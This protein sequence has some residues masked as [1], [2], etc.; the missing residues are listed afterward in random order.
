MSL[1][2]SRIRQGWLSTL[3]LGAALLLSSCEGKKTLPVPPDDGVEG[4]PSSAQLIV[5]PDTPVRVYTY[6]D[7]FPVGPSDRDSLLSVQEIYTTGPGAVQGMIF[8]FTQAERFEVFR[9]EAV[10]FR[11]LK[12]YNL[13]PVKKL[14]QGVMDLY[15]FSDP[16]PGPVGLREYLARGV[17]SGVITSRAPKTNPAEASLDTVSGMLDYTGPT[18][19]PPDYRPM[20]DSLLYMEWAPYPGAAGYWV[21]VYQFTDQGGEEIIASA[22]P[23]PIYVG[24]TRDFFLAYFPAS[25]TSYKIGDPAPPGSRIVTDPF[26]RAP[27]R[28][29]LNGLIYNVRVA[30]VD[31][32]GEMIAYTGAKETMVVFRG[33]GTYRTFALGAAQVQPAAPP[34]TPG[35]PNPAAMGPLNAGHPRVSFYPAGTG[36]L[37][38][39]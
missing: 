3:S 13:Y 29:I 8:D 23:A 18:G 25:V 35:A 26:P 5:Y 33:E 15:R 36:P 39:R 14:L 37:P 21:H 30:A 24:V 6:E 22:I 1:R 11:R 9:H 27:R 31:A 4:E 16:R 12:D 2:I 38:R 19:I 20:S 7:T 34:P 32:N 28:D 10:G 17:V